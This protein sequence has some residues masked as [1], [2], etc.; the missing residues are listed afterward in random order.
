M[1]YILQWNAKSLTANAQEFKKSLDEFMEKPEII[2]IQE[3]WLKP[4][5]DFKINGYSCERKDR[6]NRT[7]VG[8]S[9]FVKLG[10][11]KEREG[12]KLRQIWSM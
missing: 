1:F 11:Q 5:L 12:K 4:N 3:T 9:I 6:E 7:G 10:I 8:C 2:C